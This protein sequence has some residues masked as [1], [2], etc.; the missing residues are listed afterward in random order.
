MFLRRDR[1]EPQGKVVVSDSAGYVNTSVGGGTE[2]SRLHNNGVAGL[3]TDARL[4]TDA[5]LRDQL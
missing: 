1:D 2:L 4:L 5:R 3:I